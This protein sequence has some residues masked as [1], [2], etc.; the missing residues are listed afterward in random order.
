ARTTYS[1]L[2][3]ILQ[4]SYKVLNTTYPNLTQECW[5]CYDIQPPFYEAVGLTTNIRR[6]NGTNPRECTWIKRN[7]TDKAPGITLPKVTGRGVCVG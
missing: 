7:I 4:A 3:K 1:A 6:R 2:W 5:L